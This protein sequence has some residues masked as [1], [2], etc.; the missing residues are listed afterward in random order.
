MLG[1]G[2]LQDTLD[3][4]EQAVSASEFVA[5]DRFSAADVYVGSQIIFGTQFGSIPP[6]PAFLR[7]MEQLTQRPAAKR[8]KEI[9]DALIPALPAQA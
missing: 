6:R 1:Y 8:A 9:D 5:G 7:Y 3:V 4:L 2:S